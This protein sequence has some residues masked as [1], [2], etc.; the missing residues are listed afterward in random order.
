MKKKIL[1]ADDDQDFLFQTKES[2]EE[3]GYD[4]VAV[5]SQ[6]EAEE[7]L[8]SNKPDLAIFDVL[9]EN[10]DSGFILGYRIKHKYPNIPVILVTNVKAET[11]ISFSTSSPNE[12]Y[13]INADKLMNKG[14]RYDQLH[15]E[16]CKLL[17]HDECECKKH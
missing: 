5:A 7:Y 14:I 4:V 16:I 17:G 11:G 9:M 8:E 6:R 13:W 15:V 10:E 2:L 12:K 3:M 1:L